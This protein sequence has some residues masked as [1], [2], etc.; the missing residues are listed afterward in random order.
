MPR[1]I[2][3]PPTVWDF[4]KLALDQHNANRIGIQREQARRAPNP[5]DGDTGI[6][7]MHRMAEQERRRR[8]NRELDQRRSGIGDFAEDLSS[9][10]T[11][12]VPVA[13]PVARGQKK[14]FKGVPMDLGP[15][16][17][18]HEQIIT[19]IPKSAPTRFGNAPGIHHEYTYAGPNGTTIF[20]HVHRNS[21][22]YANKA[23]SKDSRYLFIVG[24]GG[25]ND[26]PVDQLAAYGIAN[27]DT[28]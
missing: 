25:E 13:V 1:G 18:P 15:S 5:L 17:L 11:P 14:R 28:R 27:R 22:G 26:I 3:P 2:P 12:P 21:S 16:L 4:I 7:A 19:R 24:K 9:L 6:A 8:E 20:I 23:H 10:F